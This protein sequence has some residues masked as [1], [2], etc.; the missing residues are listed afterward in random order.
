MFQIP[1]RH[2]RPSYPPAINGSWYISY[3]GNYPWSYF[4]A[5]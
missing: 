4:E 5:R 2:G 3:T 1:W